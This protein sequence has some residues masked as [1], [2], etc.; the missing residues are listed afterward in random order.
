MKEKE[1][2]KSKKDHL[3]S[4]TPHLSSHLI[5]RPCLITLS[6]L[7]PLI[8]NVKLDSFHFS[9]FFSFID[10]FSLLFLYLFLIHTIFRIPGIQKMIILG[11]DWKVLLHATT[12]SSIHVHFYPFS[13][14]IFSSS[15]SLI[16][17]TRELFTHKLC[18]SLEEWQIFL[19]EGG[20]RWKIVRKI[21]KCIYYK[22]NTG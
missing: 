11:Y 13:L 20:R 12:Q 3:T 9:F 15:D 7:P 1:E 2:R 17:K 21:L 5:N 8:L 6:F 22:K 16:T 4:F 18:T 10:S 14:S 19:K